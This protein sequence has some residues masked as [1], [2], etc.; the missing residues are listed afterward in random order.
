MM[1]SYDAETK[2]YVR[3]WRT[4]SYNIHFSHLNLIEGVFFLFSDVT[5]ISCRTSELE[6]LPTAR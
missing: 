5:A 1:S 3:M 2:K 4:P 6:V